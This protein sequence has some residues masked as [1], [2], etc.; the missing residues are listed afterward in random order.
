MG[1]KRRDFLKLMPLSVL[2]PGQLRSG[3]LKSQ[4]SNQIEQLYENAMVI[5]ALI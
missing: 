5:D 4:D 3:G 2:V 1:L